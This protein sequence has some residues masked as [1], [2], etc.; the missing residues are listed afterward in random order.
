MVRDQEIDGSNPFAR[1]ENLKA[2]LYTVAVRVAGFREVT[3]KDV[4]VTARQIVRADLKLAMGATAEQVT[5]EALPELINTESQAISAS[6]GSTE[7]LNLPA[8]YRGQGSTSP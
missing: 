6:F 3:L 5:V 1:S 8:N 2:G 7:V 4:V